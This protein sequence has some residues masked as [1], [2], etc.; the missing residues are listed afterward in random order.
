[1]KKHLLSLARSPLGYAFNAL[2]S[3]FQY[4]PTPGFLE[5]FLCWGCE[6]FCCADGVQDDPLF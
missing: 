2:A 3:A 5:R 6:T 4:I 1:M